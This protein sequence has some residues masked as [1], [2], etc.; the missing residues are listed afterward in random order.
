MNWLTSFL[1]ICPML[2]QLLRSAKGKLGPDHVVHEGVVLPLPTSRFCGDE[3][4]ED[5][6][7]LASAEGEARRLQERFGCD[8]SSRVLDVG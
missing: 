6:H 1:K 5:A 8:G 4:K 2:K 3:F 7:Y